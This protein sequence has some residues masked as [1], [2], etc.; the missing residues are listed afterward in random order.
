[1]A[2]HPFPKGKGFLAMIDKKEYYENHWVGKI[3]RFILKFFNMWNNGFTTSIMKAEDFLL[4]WD[5]RVPV[6]KTAKGNYATRLFFVFTSV[7][8]VRDNLDM[9]NF[10]NYTPSRTI[11]FTGPD[12]SEALPKEFVKV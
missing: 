7:R 3:T 4:F 2:I 5:S 8:W 10:Y 1:M 12:Y 6:F 11:K 9:S